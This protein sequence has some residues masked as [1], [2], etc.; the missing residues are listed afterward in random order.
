MELV[1]PAIAGLPLAPPHH[2]V[3]QGHGTW[4]ATCTLAEG[5]GRLQHEMKHAAGGFLAVEG[6]H[7]THMPTRPSPP[8]ALCHCRQQWM[9]A[10]QWELKVQ[11]VCQR[12]SCSWRQ[13]LPGPLHQPLILSVLLAGANIHVMRTLTVTRAFTVALWHSGIAL[14]T[15]ATILCCTQPSAC[16]QPL[17]SQSDNCLSAGCWICCLQLPQ[18]PCLGWA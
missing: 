1:R 7:P 13:C 17:Q 3:L 8:A 12:Q 16:T 5:I 14:T 10:L 11:Q 18:H 2:Q 6:D 9:R 4:N 15:L